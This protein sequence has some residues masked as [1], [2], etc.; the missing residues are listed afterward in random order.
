MGE[1]SHFF[2]DLLSTLPS[3]L[4]ILGSG[5]VPSTNLVGR[6]DHSY[7]TGNVQLSKYVPPKSRSYE[8]NLPSIQALQAKQGHPQ[9][10]LHDA[11]G[12]PVH[13]LGGHFRPLLCHQQA[14]LS[15]RSAGSVKSLEHGTVLTCCLL[16]SSLQGRFA[17]LQTKCYSHL[18]RLQRVAFL[19]CPPVYPHQ[20]GVQ[21]CSRSSSQVQI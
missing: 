11:R 2:S 18:D 16:G 12:G 8:N 21:V 10:V 19:L 17:H 6:T 1:N 13:R 15:L 14:A 20:G 9:H 7:Q 4:D 5:T 3:P